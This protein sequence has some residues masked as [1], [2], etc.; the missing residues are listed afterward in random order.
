MLTD[1]LWLLA[2]KQNYFNY[3]RHNCSDC[4]FSEVVV[5]W[6]SAEER[7]VSG[8]WLGGGRERTGERAREMMLTG[9]NLVCIS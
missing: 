1:M 7:G 2:I 4:L 5:K 6:F 8:H 9:W 3:R